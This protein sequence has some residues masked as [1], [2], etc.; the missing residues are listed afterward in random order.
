MFCAPGLVFDGTDGI[1]SYFHVLRALTHF[2]RYRG[3]R[4]SFSCFVLPYTFSTVPRASGPVFMFCS[5]GLIFSGTEG[6]RS[7][8]HISRSRTCFRRCRVRPVPFS[9]FVLPDSFSVFP[10][11]TNPVFMLCASGLVFGGTEGVGSRFHVPRTRT[12]FRRYGGRLVSFSCFECPDSFSAETRVSGAVFMFFAPGIVSR[13]TEGVGSHFQVLSS[14]TRFK[15][16]CGRRVPFSCFACPDSFLGLIFM[17]CASGHVFGGTEGDR[18][19]FHVLHSRTCVLRCRVRQVLFSCFVRPISFSAV[20]RATGS[21]FMFCASG[22]V[23]GGTEGG[24]SR[25]HVLPSRT[26]FRRYGGR[27][28]PISSFA[29]PE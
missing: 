2:P 9:C 1:G 18:S 27:R 25:F 28:V 12:Y 15:R 26:R 23:F 4:V 11:A 20:P 22:I 5:S 7:R 6:V 17:F 16:N 29:H 3:R 14:L 24:G 10:R 19:H 8:F 13:G 21:V